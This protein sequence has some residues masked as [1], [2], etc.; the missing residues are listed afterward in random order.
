[1]WIPLSAVLWGGLATLW[2]PLYDLAW[3]PG[4][5]PITFAGQGE[6]GGLLR[7][8]ASAALVTGPIL[9]WMLRRPNCAA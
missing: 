7:L 8:T 6:L 5:L 9:L 4:R 3:L 2:Y 1:L